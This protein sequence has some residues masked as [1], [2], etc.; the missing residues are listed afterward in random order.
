MKKL[1]TAIYT[2]AAGTAL[3]ASVGGR[4][5]KGRAP[6]G[7][8]YPYIVYRVISDV[9][10]GTF[11]EDYEDYLIEFNIFSA[12]P[13]STNEVETILGYLTALY[14]ECSLSISSGGG[15]LLRMWR[16]NTT[17]ISEEHTT[18][19]GTAEVW[20]YAVDYAVLIEKP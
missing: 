1:T 7:A 17:P 13:Y 12:D 19:A 2:K 16:Q 18:P 8:Q 20:H 3:H 9:P 6:E 5:Y 11:T 15:Y 10:D 4:I 14:D